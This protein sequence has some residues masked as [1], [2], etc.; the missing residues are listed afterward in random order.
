MTLWH[1][2]IQFQLQILTTSCYTVSENLVGP[3]RCYR[4]LGGCWSHF[5]M[6]RRSHCLFQTPV[7][8]GA[9]QMTLG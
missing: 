6:S 2:F 3:L 8:N 4:N 7:Q 9:E 1:C 5:S